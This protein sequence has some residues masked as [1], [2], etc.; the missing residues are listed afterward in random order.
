MR[1]RIVTA[2]LSMSPS[3]SMAGSVSTEP[4]ALSH[5]AS[6]PSAHRIQRKTSKSWISMSRKIPPEAWM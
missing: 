6:S 1:V 2:V 5:C 4:V 3:A